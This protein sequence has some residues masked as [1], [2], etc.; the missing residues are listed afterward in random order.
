MNMLPGD[1]KAMQPSGLRLGVP[2]LTRVGMGT[3]EMTDVAHF[4]ARALIKKAD[5]S[6]IKSDVKTFKSSYQTVKYCF[7]SGPAYPNLV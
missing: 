7:E 2:E 6:K 4:F 3:D 5:P 1:T